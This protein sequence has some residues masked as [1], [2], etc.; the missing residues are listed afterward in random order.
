MIDQRVGVHVGLRIGGLDGEPAVGGTNAA[1]VLREEV[2]LME[3]AVEGEMQELDRV[4]D[5]R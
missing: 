4:R 3:G 1:V 5:H 2:D